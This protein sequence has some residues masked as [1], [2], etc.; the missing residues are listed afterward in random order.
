MP[1]VKNS[2]G[3]RIFLAEIIPNPVKRMR[4]HLEITCEFGFEVINGKKLAEIAG[5]R[6]ILGTS[7]GYSKRRTNEGEEMKS[8]PRDSVYIF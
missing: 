7:V 6:K 5:K 8:S 2:E 3:R 4:K 1:E